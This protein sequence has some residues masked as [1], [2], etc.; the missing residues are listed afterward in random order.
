MITSKKEGELTYKITQLQREKSELLKQ[1]A[2]LRDGL[3]EDSDVV[4][5]AELS[6]QGLAYK[7]S[8]LI[9]QIKRVADGLLNKQQLTQEEWVKRNCHPCIHVGVPDDE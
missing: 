2:L 4:F 5:V 8:Q 6:G 3:P 9:L 7:E 1:N